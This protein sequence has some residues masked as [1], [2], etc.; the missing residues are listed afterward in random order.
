MIILKLFIIIDNGVRPY[1]LHFTIGGF[2][3]THGTEIKLFAGNSNRALAEAIAKHLQLPLSDDL[4]RLIAQLIL[5]HGQSL[6][7]LNS[8]IQLILF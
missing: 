4:I 1:I 3:I 6:S 5:Q 8:L 2:M 7:E